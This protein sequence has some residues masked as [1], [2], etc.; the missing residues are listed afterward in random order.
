[1]VDIISKAR[2]YMKSGT[3]ILAPAG[4]PDDLDDVMDDLD[5]YVDI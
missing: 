2:T 3:G 1:M 5:M 4:K